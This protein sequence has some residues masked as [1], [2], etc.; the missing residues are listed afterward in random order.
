MDENEIMTGAEVAELL[1]V[2]VRTLDDWRL[3]RTGP[4][5]RKMGRHVRYLRSEVLAWFEGLRTH[6]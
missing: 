2:S 5:Y 6:G 1:Q 3:H 4:P